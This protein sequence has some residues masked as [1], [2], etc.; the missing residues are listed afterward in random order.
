MSKFGESVYSK[1]KAKQS[2]KQKLNELYKK[3][4]NYDWDSLS[5]VLAISIKILKLELGEK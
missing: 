3:L 1:K 5:E 4:R 2:K